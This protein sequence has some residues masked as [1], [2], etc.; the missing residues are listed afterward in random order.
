MKR[1]LQSAPAGEGLAL[2][3]GIVLLMWAVEVINSIFSPGAEEIADARDVVRLYEQA[4][5]SGHPAVQRANG[6]ALLAHQYKDALRT[7]ARSR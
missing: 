4:A 5:A 7:L 6:E 3:A 1:R 2:L